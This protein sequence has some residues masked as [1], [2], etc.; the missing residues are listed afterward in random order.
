M[1]RSVRAGLRWALAT[2]LCIPWGVNPHGTARAQNRT[3]P[4]ETTRAIPARNIPVPATVSPELARIIA[5]TP[6]HPTAP[7]TAQ[8]WK[9]AVQA[10][11]T[12][13][14]QR[15]TAVRK[16]FAVTVEPLRVAGVPC[17]MITPVRLSDRNR[18]R[19]LMHLH[20][21]GYV[22]G[23]GE[24]GTLEGIIMAGFSGMKVLSVDYRMPPE[25]PYPAAMDDAT[26]VWKA[27]TQREQPANMAVFGT[28]TGGGMTLA[29]VQRAREEK[30]P[31]PAAIAPGTPWSDLTKTGDSYFVNEGV[32]NALVAYEPLLSASARLYAGAV[33]L[34]DPH[35]SP[36]YGSFSGF[37][38]TLLTTGTRDLFLSN[39]VRVH[40]KLR[41][42]GVDARLEV[43]EGQSHAQYLVDPTA[44]ESRE[45]FEDIAGF[46]DAHLGT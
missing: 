8:D 33:D 1:H 27:L 11:A 40:R 41:E 28:S 13:D 6:M 31:L 44:P 16:Q 12:M 30:L 10:A 26:A 3:S 46:F 43:Y 38:P 35:L 20:G 45:A 15:I 42:A 21:G 19:L 34:E 2:L 7:R 25:H 14:L 23:P 32:D 9:A 17:F 4:T 24:S 5:R 37:P 22:F 18:H 29:L 36:V 39:T